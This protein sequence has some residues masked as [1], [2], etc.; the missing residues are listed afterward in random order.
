[1]TL[2]LF[3]LLCLGELIPLRAFGDIR[4]KMPSKVL[5][6]I[7][8][9]CGLPPSYP[10][11]P[12][13]YTSP[14]YLTATPQIVCHRLDHARDRFVILAS[15]GLWDMLTPNQ[16]VC[17]VAQ[18]YLDYNGVRP[19]KKFTHHPIESSFSQITLFIFQYILMLFFP[20]RILRLLDRATPRR[21]G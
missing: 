19:S 21:V 2:D 14:P 6:G 16:A 8:R 7:A 20:S 17:V 4:Y 12:R 18:H 3:V 1:M 11:T 5:K 10:V 13:F 9:L 15:D